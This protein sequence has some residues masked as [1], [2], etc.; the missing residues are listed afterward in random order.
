MKKFLNIGLIFLITVFL[1]SGN[2]IEF[3]K[4][5]R[6]YQNSDWGKCL[7][8]VIHECDEV[9]WADTCISGRK[10]TEFSCDAVDYVV[11]DYDR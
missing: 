8:Y 11:D 4:G 9:N 7:S 3:E 5:H 1:R 2:V 6:Y 10:R